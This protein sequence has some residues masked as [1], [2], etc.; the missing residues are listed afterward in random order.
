MKKIIAMTVAAIFMAT[1]TFA[2]GLSVGAKGNLGT[3]VSNDWAEVSSDFASMTINSEF[4]GGFGAY[5]NLSIMGGLGLMVEADVTNS[6]IQ[7]KGDASNLISADDYTTSTFDAWLIDVPVMLWGNIDLWKLRLVMCVGPNFSFN[8][9]AADRDSLGTTAEYL[10]KVYAE[11]MYTMGLALGVDA[12]FFVTDNIGIV[13][14]GRYI[15]NFEK[16]TATYPIKGSDEG[17]Q[18]PSVEFKRNSF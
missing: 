1:S 4:D 10:K 11:K 8:L 18:Y 17:I 16:T 15:G 14:S 6:K 3:T 2:L 7:F 12:K 9:D 5:V 13:A